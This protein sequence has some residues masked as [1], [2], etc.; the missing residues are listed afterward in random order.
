MN[1]CC[2]KCI[3]MRQLANRWM[4]CFCHERYMFMLCNKIGLPDQLLGKPDSVLDLSQRHWRLVERRRC[5]NRGYVLPTH[6]WV[7][8]LL[9]TAPTPTDIID[10]TDIPPTPLTCR[11]RRPTTGDSAG[12]RPT[13]YAVCTRVQILCDEIR[14]RN[15]DFVDFT[16][17]INIL[18]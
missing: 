11:I 13:Y 18:H 7:W 12:T 9:K 4:S 16:L 8:V 3:P 5:E 6:P 2:R 14:I 15:L 17:V 10:T 1:W